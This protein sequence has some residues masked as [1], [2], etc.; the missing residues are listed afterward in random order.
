MS[1][2]LA[3]TIRI[4]RQLADELERAPLPTQ[5]DFAVEQVR[6][7]DAVVKRTGGEHYWTARADNM[8]IGDSRLGHG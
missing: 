7:I 3:E 2:H 8:G 1:E 5:A 6:W 4:G